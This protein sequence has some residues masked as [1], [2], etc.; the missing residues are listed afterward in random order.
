MSGGAGEG[1]AR[2]VEGQVRQL[3]AEAQDPE[4]LCRMYAGWAPWL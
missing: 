2:G 1:D 3:L 4:L